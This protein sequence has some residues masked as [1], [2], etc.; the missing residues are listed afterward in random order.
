MNFQV[1]VPMH[2]S[3]RRYLL[4]NHTERTCVFQCSDP[5]TL[6]AGGSQLVPHQDPLKRAHVKIWADHCTDRI[7][8]SY[9]IA[10]ME[11]DSSKQQVRSDQGY[12]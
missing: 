2:A 12:L 9:Y 7:Q 5:G 10:L 3:T 6:G 11:Q 4:P 8:K 1:S